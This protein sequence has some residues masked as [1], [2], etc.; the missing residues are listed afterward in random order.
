M[1]VISLITDVRRAID[2]RMDG[3]G[4]KASRRIEISTELNKYYF[5][6]RQA[7]RA[8]LNVI[9]PRDCRLLR[10]YKGIMRP[11]DSSSTSQ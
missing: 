7:K 5:D 6:N 9:H 1:T 11:G 2:G 3:R 8:R 4:E 10:N